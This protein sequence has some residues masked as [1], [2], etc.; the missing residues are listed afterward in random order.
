MGSIA[1]HLLAAQN[2]ARIIRAHDVA[3]V[4]QQAATERAAGVGAGEVL[5]GEAARRIQQETTLERVP[6]I[7]LVTGYGRDDVMEDARR[8]N[9]DGY[10]LKPVTQSVLFDAIMG[11][12]G[13][14]TERGIEKGRRKAE[15]PRY[16]RSKASASETRSR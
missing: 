13:R 1:A 6:K 14:H 11:A 4:G 12:F 7:I 2:G 9:L 5:G 3:D 8:C 10:L 16:S 15:T